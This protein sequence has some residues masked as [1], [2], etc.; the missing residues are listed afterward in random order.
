VNLKR[1]T[2]PEFDV[3]MVRRA[4]VAIS[5][6]LRELL[7]EKHLYQSVT[8]SRDSLDERNCFAT[9]YAQGAKDL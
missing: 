5:A 1:E 2:M 6:A 3:D 4:A 9:R 7:E 8:V